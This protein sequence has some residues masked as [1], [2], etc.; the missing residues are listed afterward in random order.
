M[1]SSD[2]LTLFVGAT[3][4]RTSAA[5]TATQP[6]VGILSS[7]TVALDTGGVH[8]LTFGGADLTAIGPGANFSQTITVVNASTVTVPSPMTDIALWLDN[9][10]APAD[11]GDLGAVLQVTITRS[12]GGGAAATLYAGSLAGL[13]D[14][15][16]F[17][18]P[19]GALWSSECRVGYGELRD[20]CHV[21]LQFLAPCEQ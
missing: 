15:T 21:H 16:G 17:A 1:C 19:I 7:G 3:A 4:E 18:S 11:P 9:A 13:V 5:F 20:E 10:S 6:V 14:R 2:L 12:I 8:R